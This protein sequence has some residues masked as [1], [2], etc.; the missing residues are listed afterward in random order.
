MALP[1]M[2][3]GYAQ[4]QS[5]RFSALS[6]S[7]AQLGQQ[8][9]Q[10][11]A[12]REYQRQ[13]QAELP[14]MQ[15]AMNRAMEKV[16]TGNIAEG[17]R[18]MLTM[19]P[20]NSTNPYLQQTAQGMMGLLD[21]ASEFEYKTRLMKSQYGGGE[22]PS[23]TNIIDAMNQGDVGED[24]VETDMGQPA[25]VGPANAMR[26]RG[27]EQA[28]GFPAMQDQYAGAAAAGQPFPFKSAREES[29]QAMGM[30]QQPLQGTPEQ[31]A[32]QAQDMNAYLVEPAL[33]P[34]ESEKTLA[35][36]PV[37]EKTPPPIDI[38]KKFIKYTDQ[39][40]K[41]PIRE[42]IEDRDKSSIMFRTQ[43]ALDKYIGEKKEGRQIL[44]V[45]PQSSLAVPGV[46]GV[47]LPDEISKFVLA[48]A[49]VGNKT[50]YRIDEKTKG[51]AKAKAAVDWLNTW[52][53]TAVDL[54]SSPEI[55]NLFE[56]AGNDALN[57]DASTKPRRTGSDEYTLQ[58]RDNPNTAI[59]V[60]KDTFN[61]VQI[62]RT[63]TAAAKTHGAKFIRVEQPKSQIK[64]QEQSAYKSADDVVSAIKSGKLTREQ[65]KGILQNQFGY[66]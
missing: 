40:A 26:L 18:E 28:S 5:K 42:Q 46:I 21:K 17:Y 22:R 54:E 19:M 35:K 39:F 37:A 60:D 66:K 4:D 16:Q 20:W 53:E 45:A 24:Y 61:K 29:S 23:I 11:L 27:A 3:Q 33:P 8:V 44:D 62:L 41:M 49:T 32:M 64:T 6:Q 9:G 2:I 12:N 34:W 25:A 47:E 31:Q 55:R 51:S 59:K 36:G 65:G 1:A 43:G 58:V 56:Q 7:L 15:E 13:A 50:S 10:Q 63:Q 48:G 57:I 30:G 52:Q 38:T 14:Y